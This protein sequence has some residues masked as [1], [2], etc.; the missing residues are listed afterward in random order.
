MNKPTMQNAATFFSRPEFKAAIA[1]LYAARDAAMNGGDRPMAEA[2]EALAWKMEDGIH[3]IRL[4]DLEA[5]AE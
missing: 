5:E 4:L 2:Y 1:A 3:A